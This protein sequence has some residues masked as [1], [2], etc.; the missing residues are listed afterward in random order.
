MT[1]VLTAILAAALMEFTLRIWFDSIQWRARL[2]ESLFAVGIGLSALGTALVQPKLNLPL[3]N[4][5]SD[6]GRITLFIALGFFI[7]HLHRVIFVPGYV[8]SLIIHHLGMITCI[9]CGL[10][11]DFGYYYILI[12]SVPITSAAI[13]NSRWFWAKMRLPRS[14][15][16]AV[17]VAISYVVFET[18]PPL[19]ALVHLFTIGIHRMELTPNIWAFMVAPG[20][21][22]GVLTFYW[23]AIFIKKAIPRKVQFAEI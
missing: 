20:L 7:Y 14:R 23:S 9:A 21:V 2:V 12:A 3:S 6:F 13:R 19:W 5:V 1:Y 17:G 18:L 11:F 4:G 10:A 16:K 15:R 8:K 22:L